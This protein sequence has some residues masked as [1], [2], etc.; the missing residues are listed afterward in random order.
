MNQYIHQLSPFALQFTETMGIRWY[1][2]AYLMAFI[3]AYAF[4]DYMAKTKRILLTRDQ[5][6]DFITYGA[7]GVLG[8]GRLGYALFY[9]PELLTHFS[10]QFPFWGVLEVHKGGMASHGGIL[11]VLLAC[12]IFGRRHKIPHMH[13]LDL[14]TIA[15]S[16]GFLFGRIANFINGELYGREAPAD[17]SWAVKFPQEIYHWGANEVDKLMSL[18]PAAEVFGTNSATWADWINRYDQSA[19]EQINHMKELIVSGTQAHNAALLDALAPVL[20]PRY[21]S[22]LIQC[23]LEGFLVFL[24]L[25][26]VWRKPQKIG[27]LSGT[28]GFGYCLARIVGEAYR[29]PDYGIGYQWLGLTRGQWLSIAMAVVALAILIYSI[30]RPGQKIGGWA[31]APELAGKK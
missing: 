14:T 24:V 13:L 22:Q 4:I 18:G 10:G 15:G 19:R 7:I 26:W 29:L 11:G 31:V 27:V 6:S 30:R 9:S 21:P 28:F 5:V 16:L 1:G 8:G 3:C 17:L 2:L 20:T 12:Y 23:F 25:I